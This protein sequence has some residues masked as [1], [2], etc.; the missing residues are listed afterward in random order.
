MASP[1]GFIAM[2][3]VPMLSSIRERDGILQQTHVGRFR[4]ALC[5]HQAEFAMTE[6]CALLM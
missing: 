1:I 5:M 4:Q 3:R 2:R 6:E